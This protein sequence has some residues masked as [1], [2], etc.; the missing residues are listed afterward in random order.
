MEPMRWN[1][2][3]EAADFLTG[4]TGEQW[5]A[6]RIIDAGER[7]LIDVRAVLPAGTR[8]SHFT[9]NTVS[10]EGVYLD[11]LLTHSILLVHSTTNRWLN[12]DIELEPPATFTHAD[13]VIMGRDLEA[14]AGTLA[15]AATPGA[16]VE[17]ATDTTT[18]GDDWTEKARSIADECFDKDTSLNC[19][20]S[21]KGYSKRVMEL[22]QERGIK[23]SRGIID[24]AN[25]VMRAALQ[26]KKWW[27]NKSK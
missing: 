17:A 16:K 24:N 11:H 26:G 5:T 27:A 21:L 3:Q 15:T 19:R 20:N 14:F 18:P 2:L 8:T 7:G 25:Y 4:N 12:A 23:G 6:R 10:L 13:L 1:T 22:M 9:G